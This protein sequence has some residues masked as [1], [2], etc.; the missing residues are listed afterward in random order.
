MLS[1]VVVRSGSRTT[2]GRLY[3]RIEKEVLDLVAIDIETI[4]GVKVAKMK[5]RGKQA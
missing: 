1:I 2:I 3:S 4:V 5:L